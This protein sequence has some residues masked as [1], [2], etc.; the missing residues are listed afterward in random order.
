MDKNNGKILIVDDNQEILTALKYFLEDYFET[1][2]TE[3]NPKNIPALIKA[4]KFDIFI[5]D[6]NFT[7]G[8]NSGQEGI[9]WM[10]Q[11]IKTDPEAI[12]IFITAYGDIELSVKA[13][14]Q[15]ATDFITKPWDSNKLLNTVISAFKLKKS[16]FDVLNKK[17]KNNQIS[18]F[19][20]TPNFIVGNSVSMLKLWETIKK[21]SQTNA[22]VLLLGENG[23]GKDLIALEIHKHSLRHNEKFIKVDIGSLSETLFES[24][25]FGHKK[26]A[27]TDAFEER[28]GKIEEANGGTLFLDEIA[29]IPVRMQSKLLTALQNHEISKVGSNI[30][31]KMDIRLIT[32]TN[33]NLINMVSKNEFREDLFY[34]INTIQIEIPPL[35]ERIDDLP[36]LFNH[37]LKHFSNLYNKPEPEV[38]SKIIDN[39]KKHTWPGNV[40]ELEHIVEKAVILSTDNKLSLDDFVF[41]GQKLNLSDSLS[42]ENHEKQLILKALEK[43][44]GNYSKAAQELGIARKTLYNKMIRY[45]I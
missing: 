20:N 18:N 34:R 33:R 9:F 45:G 14:K 11:I 23:T 35:R 44:K 36:I 17:T 10:N 8:E 30:I 13:I 27:F 31:S 41:P 1:V 37:F 22:N 7:L 29:N 26:G 25:L 42:L 38:N 3:K 2:I 6:M 19:S 5:L 32:A 16:R 24:E 21:V 43:S 39:L 12:I 28:T 15:G 4:N 40:R